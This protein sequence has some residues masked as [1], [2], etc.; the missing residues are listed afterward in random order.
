MDKDILNELR[1]KL[2]KLGNMADD[3]GLRHI[4]DWT[5]EIAPLLNSLCS[6]GVEYTKNKMSEMK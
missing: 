3:C 2:V 6:Y 4:G 5:M 1:K